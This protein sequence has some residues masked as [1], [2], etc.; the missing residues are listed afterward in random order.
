M[1]PNPAQFVWSG[2][3]LFYIAILKSLYGKEKVPLTPLAFL[4]PLLTLPFTVLWLTLGAENSTLVS[5]VWGLGIAWIALSHFQHFLFSIKQKDAARARY[6]LLVLLM[7]L[8]DEMVLFFELLYT[9]ADY[10]RFN[11]YYLFDLLVTLALGLQVLALKKAE[12]V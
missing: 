6:C 4:A 5:L 9:P 11:G 7:L 12:A 2:G 10:L 3:H 1:E 8:F